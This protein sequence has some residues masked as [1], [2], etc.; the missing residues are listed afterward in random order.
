[1]QVHTDN[2]GRCR[3][4]L[5]HDDIIRSTGFIEA[6]MDRVR[7]RGGNHSRKNGTVCLELQEG[8]L[9]WQRTGMGIVGEEVGTM[10]KVVCGFFQSLGI[11]L[12]DSKGNVDNMLP[13]VGVGI[14]SGGGVD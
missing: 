1:M 12:T 3:S 7:V 13:S 2:I 6:D 14:G 4:Q 9:C 5:Q 11:V 8:L 10:V